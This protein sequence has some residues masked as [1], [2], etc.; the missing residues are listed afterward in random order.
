MLLA[1]ALAIEDMSGANRP[2]E[3]TLSPY[4]TLLLAGNAALLVRVWRLL[5]GA[6]GAVGWGRAVGAAALLAY[7]ALCG[8][9]L[10]LAASTAVDV[11]LAG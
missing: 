10:A 1:V 3:L 5:R 8:L 6:G 4:V 9:L 7:S 11:L 2:H